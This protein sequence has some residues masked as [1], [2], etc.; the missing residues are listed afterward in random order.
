ML[1]FKGSCVHFSLFIS[2][3][4]GGGSFASRSEQTAVNQQFKSGS[5]GE[6]YKTKRTKVCSGE[7]GNGGVERRTQLAGQG[8][9]VFHGGIQPLPGGGFCGQC[10]SRQGQPLLLVWDLGAEEGRRLQAGRGRGHHCVPCRDVGPRHTSPG[11]AL[12]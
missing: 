6:P 1:A 7:G 10:H 9:P 8:L 11:S 5:M 4:G 3:K 2:D 12:S